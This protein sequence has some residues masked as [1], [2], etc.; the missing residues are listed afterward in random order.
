MTVTRI[1][2]EEKLI[3]ETKKQKKDGGP[4]P[5]FLVLGNMLFDVA[6]HLARR[7][8]PL[9]HV[10]GGWGEWGAAKRCNSKAVQIVFVTPPL[11]PSQL[12]IAGGGTK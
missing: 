8:R 10:T 1:N 4:P 7:T 5:L 2:L 3:S 6:M 9:L 11:S 12:L